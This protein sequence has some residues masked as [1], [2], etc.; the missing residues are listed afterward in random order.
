M[1]I[2]NTT[3]SPKSTAPS[4]PK[5]RKSRARAPQNAISVAAASR[6][7]RRLVLGTTS[8]AGAAVAA[9]P[10]VLLRGALHGADHRADKH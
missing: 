2:V 1:T 7:P 3:E 5:T 8:L 9:A 10:A 6:K 4:S